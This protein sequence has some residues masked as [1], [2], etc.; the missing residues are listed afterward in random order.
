M[1]G[2]FVSGTATS[3]FDGLL[4]EIL[5]VYSLRASVFILLVVQKPNPAK[6]EFSNSQSLA[7]KAKELTTNTI[8]LKLIINFVLAKITNK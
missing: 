6:A 8:N 2:V 1:E 5:P 4:E 3:Y 7:S